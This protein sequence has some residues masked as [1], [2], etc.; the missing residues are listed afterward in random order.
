MSDVRLPTNSLSPMGITLREITPGGADLDVVAALEREID[1]EHAGS[2]DAMRADDR[3]L[4]DGGWGVVRKVAE[5]AGTSVGHAAARQL[6]TAVDGRTFITRVAVLPQHHREGIGARL[7]SEVDRTLPE[8]RVLF[9]YVPEEPGSV[10]FAEQLGYASAERT[11]ELSID[12]RTVNPEPPP[13][14]IRIEPISR[15]IDTHP[16]WFDRLHDLFRLTVADAPFPIEEH[17]TPPDVFRARAVDSPTADPEAILIAIEGSE[18]VG[19]TNL[20]RSA[21]DPERWSQ[22]FTGVSSD[23]RGRG[24]ATALKREGLRVVARKGAISV[25]TMNHEDNA[26][27]LASNKRLGFSPTRCVHLMIQKR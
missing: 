17:E 18:W 12:P 11:V 16:D 4:I 21:S 20:R 15:L 14:G 19:F 23:H 7:H 13:A 25:G 3:T 5:N 8:G 22:M 2:P 6:P 10:E 9:S 24:I 27:I 26:G 1:S